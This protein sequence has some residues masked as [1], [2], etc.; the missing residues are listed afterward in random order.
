MTFILKK[1]INHSFYFTP[2]LWE[3]PIQKCYW[4]L[5]L[6]TPT[7]QNRE[8]TQTGLSLFDHFVGLALKVLAV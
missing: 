5:D 3:L 7:S 4:L 2:N 1:K 8:N 6:S